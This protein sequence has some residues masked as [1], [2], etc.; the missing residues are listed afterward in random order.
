[1]VSTYDLSNKGLLFGANKIGKKLTATNECEREINWQAER[2][3]EGEIKRVGY[4]IR[5]ACLEE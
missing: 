2:I 4:K 5:T 3:G 1:L